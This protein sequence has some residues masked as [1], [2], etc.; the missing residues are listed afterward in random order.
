M[1]FVFLRKEQIIR[2]EE[3]K[4]SPLDTIDAV[5]GLVSDLSFIFNP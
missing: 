1:H 4:K 5:A 3:P 2:Y